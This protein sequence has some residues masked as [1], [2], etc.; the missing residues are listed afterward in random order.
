M[1]ALP[2]LALLLSPPALAVPTTVHHQGRVFDALGDPM[3]GSDTVTLSLYDTPSGGTALWTETVSSSF[4]DGYF[5]ETFGLSTAFDPDDF[6]DSDL[7]FE[8]SIGSGPALTPRLLTTSVP[9]AFAADH[10]EVAAYADEAGH[11]ATADSVSGSAAL[12]VSSVSINGT[13]VIAADG[14]IDW[15]RIVNAAHTHAAADIDA[16]TI[17]MDRLP[18]GTGTDN[19]ARGDH[20]HTASDTTTG[21]FDFDRLPV[22]T[23]STTVSRGDHAHDFSAITGSVATSQLPTGGTIQLGDSTATCDSSVEGTL[24]YNTTDKQIEFCD[25]SDW[26]TGQP[27]LGSADD[28]AFSCKEILDA[29]DSEGSGE[30]WV[31]RQGSPVRTWCDMTTDGGGW[32]R[33]ASQ[34]FGTTGRYL[35]HTALTTDWGTVGSDQWGSDCLDLMN[36]VR[37]S[38]D[39]EFMLLG[40]AAGEW[41][42]IWPFDVQDFTERLGGDGTDCGGPPVTECKGS[43][44]SSSTSISGVTQACHGGGGHTGDSYFIW[45]AAAGG[46]SNVLMELGTGDSNHP[47]GIRTDCSNSGWWGGCGRPGNTYPYQNP[48]WCNS[49]Q[50]ERGTVKVQFRER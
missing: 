34:N 49:S 19:V 43:A 29:G 48:S 17:H 13:E 33:C 24:R 14:T 42:W 32:T 46:N 39:V 3:Q 47:V 28:P 2:L 10:A 40:D 21:T 4:T 11:A 26:V 45:Q 23:T 6:G 18:V 16:G 41:Q 9:F 27:K 38:G 15:G 31:L 25:G 7:Y 44:M 22:G 50:R 1:R 20:I 36:T 30:Y 35:G 5:A 37:P 8:V 12:D